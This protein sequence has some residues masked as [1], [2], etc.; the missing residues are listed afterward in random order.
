MGKTHPSGAPV[1]H[2]GDQTSD[3]YITTW[4]RPWQG[5]ARGCRRPEEGH[6]HSSES[7]KASCRRR[8]FN[9]ILKAQKLT[10]QGKRAVLQAKSSHY[11]SPEGSRVPLWYG[12]A[13]DLSWPSTSLP[14]FT[15]PLG[16]QARCL[17]LVRM[18]GGAPTRIPQPITWVLPLYLSF[19][20]V[21]A[22]WD[23]TVWWW[24][25]RGRG[26]TAWCG[27]S[28]RCRPRSGPKVS[29]PS[30]G[31]ITVLQYCCCGDS[32]IFVKC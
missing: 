23:S 5:K 12:F 2:G 22:S 11:P 29:H 25:A 13:P 30:N 6:R 9:W 17:I 28:A 15:S 8:S 19:L 31:V 14:L 26:Q 27:S 16:F 3:H 4:Q 1:F 10:K 32:V 20:W 24:R 18:S 21:L 7:R